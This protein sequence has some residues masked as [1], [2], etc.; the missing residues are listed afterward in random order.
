MQYRKGQL[1]GYIYIYGSPAEMQA[2]VHWNEI[3]RRVTTRQLVLSQHCTYP[4]FL[5][6]NFRCRTE[7]LGSRFENAVI[8]ILFYVSKLR[9]SEHA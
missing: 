2:P 8:S 7:R 3:D 4:V 5:S 9:N 6:L 1:D